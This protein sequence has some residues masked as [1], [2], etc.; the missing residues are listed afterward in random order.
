MADI[1]MARI[2]KASK[3][4]IRVKPETGRGLRVAGFALRVSSCEFRVAGVSI[5]DAGF[6]ILD[7]GNRLPVAEIR[8]FAGETRLAA[9]GVRRTPACRAHRAWRLALNRIL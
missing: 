7:A 1:T 5:L 9:C 6:W 4:S 3:I 8:V 2:K